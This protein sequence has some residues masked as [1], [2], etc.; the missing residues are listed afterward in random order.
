MMIIKVNYAKLYNYFIL[1]IILFHSTKT[2]KESQKYILFIDFK[3]HTILSI[4]TN[5]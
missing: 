5:L 1:L 3:K 2:Y 4:E